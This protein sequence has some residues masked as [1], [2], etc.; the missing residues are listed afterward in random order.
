MDGAAAQA[1]VLVTLEQDLELAQDVAQVP[2]LVQA[3]AEAWAWAQA[4]VLVGGQ[5]LELGQAWVLEPV[6][7]LD[8]EVV[9]DL[10]LE[11]DLVGR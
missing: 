7:E 11:S 10:A 9:Q 2:G 5:A 3:L 8:S 4:T 1:P 6:L